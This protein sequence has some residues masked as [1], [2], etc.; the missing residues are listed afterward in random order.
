MQSRAEAE[1][2]T[3]NLNRT[4]LKWGPLLVL[5]AAFAVTAAAC[6]DD[7]KNNDGSDSTSGGDTS[8]ADGSDG[9]SGT[10]GTSIGDIGDCA[11]AQNPGGDDDGDGLVNGLED[12]NLNCIVDPGETDPLNPDSDGDGI[13]DG[14]EDINRN[15]RVDP[16][17][18]DPTKSDTDGNGIP[19]GE[20]TGALTCTPS[21]LQ[22]VT[23]RPVSS[24]ETNTAFP[25]SFTIQQH[26]AARGATFSDPT[27][28]AFGFVVSVNASSTN[29]LQENGQ[30][31]FRVAS[32]N[33]GENRPT[34]ELQSSFSFPDPDWIPAPQV[35]V[36]AVQGVRAQIR[37]LPPAPKSP[38]QLRDELISAVSGSPVTSGESAATC[39]D[40]QVYWNSQLRIDQNAGNKLVISAVA[41]CRDAVQNSESLLFL[42]ED[43]LSGTTV[44]PGAYDPVDFFC[45]DVPPRQEIGAADFLWVIDNSGSMSDEQ[46]NVAAAV[47]TF[48]SVLMSSGIDWRLGVTTTETYHIAPGGNLA[49]L[50][51][52]ELMNT[53]TGLR[54]PGFITPE[55]LDAAELFRRNVTVD[56]G[57]DR[58]DIGP[59]DLNICGSGLE[60]GLLSSSIV[61][62]RL[63]ENTTAIDA[64]ADRH[65]LRE[66]AVRIVIW[67]SDEENHGIRD[68]LPSDPAFQQFVTGQIAAHREH[69]VAAFAIVGDPGRDNGGVCEPLDLED[70]AAVTGAVFGVSYIEA[71]RALGGAESSI[72]T[73]DLRPAIEAIVRRA[74]GAAAAYPLAKLPISSS[75]RVAVDGQLIPRSTTAGWNYDADQNAIVFYG[76]TRPT[77]DSQIAVSYLLWK[78][79]DG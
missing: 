3:L 50:T 30:A 31:L 6:A 72:C 74:V 9:T 22:S 8:G 37:F 15:G 48:L 40:L 68:L 55:D 16:G 43:V 20:E 78:R 25:G 35:T 73:D 77:A 7:P 63:A 36:P 69:D 61:L 65:A 14:D 23:A 5:L 76:N 32:A 12:V 41:A 34:V 24:A 18:F 58:P 51:H 56:I 28:G 42:F 10:D 52:D 49:V 17:E 59:P 33:N 38:A 66:G 54:E 60:E 27:S 21:L 1:D 46:D 47:D 29:P 2:L 79:R 67:L 45:E 71:A 70:P 26:T 53:T 62:E 11:T 64:P 4:R 19:D 75:I 39:A 57:C 44:A 13:L